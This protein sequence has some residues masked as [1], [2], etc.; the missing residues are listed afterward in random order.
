MAVFWIHIVYS[1]SQR[2]KSILFFQDPKTRLLCHKIH[3]LPT[4]SRVWRGSDPYYCP[5]EFI[6]TVESMYFCPP[7]HSTVMEDPVSDII[8]TLKTQIAATRLYVD[9]TT[10]Y[11]QLNPHD[12][13]VIP[14]LAAAQRNL[15]R[16]LTA[17]ECMEG[18]E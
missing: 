11:M 16:L 3:L 6:P 15:A 17:L 14:V 2:I 5:C 10:F 13:R 12:T 18:M 9:K 4:P 8:E 7:I 1:Y